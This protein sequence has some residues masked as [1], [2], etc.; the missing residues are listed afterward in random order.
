M[1]RYRD[2]M[3]PRTF[4]IYNA[5][6][7]DHAAISVSRIFVLQVCPS[8]DLSTSSGS[9]FSLPGVTGWAPSPNIALM[10]IYRHSTH[11]M[12]TWMLRAILSEKK[13]CVQHMWQSIPSERRRTRRRGY[14]EGGAREISSTSFENIPLVEQYVDHQIKYF[15]KD[16]TTSV[17][18]Q[19]H[20]LS[21]DARYQQIQEHL[22]HTKKLL[23]LQSWPPHRQQ[24]TRCR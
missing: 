9:W 6:P 21:R 22:F 2:V 1:G 17:F 8:A 11:L 10:P 24:S 19:N 20:S 18:S 16:N 13:K 3:R 23:L 15:L 14:F 7:L 5:L 4:G 12:R